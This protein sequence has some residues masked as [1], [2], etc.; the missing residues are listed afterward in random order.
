MTK[1]T[2]PKRIGLLGPFG[3]GNLGDAAIQHSMIQHIRKYFP[4]AQIYAF[5]MNPADTTAS[6]HIPAF[7]ITRL[8][9]KEFTKSDVLWKS[10]QLP[11]RVA[12]W[13]QYNPNPFIRRLEKVIVRVPAEMILA[14]RA[15]QNIKGL[16]MLIFSGGGQLDDLW[17][18]PWKHPYVLFKFSI[19]ARLQKIKVIFVSVGLESARTSLG[20]FFMKVALSQ[21]CYKS[22]RDKRSKEMVE[23]LKLDPHGDSFVY[24]D[25]A[26]SLEVMALP[27]TQVVN[28]SKPVVGFNPVPFYDPRFWPLKDKT[29]YQQYL[30]KMA[31]FV[32]WLIERQY[33]VKLIRSD[34][35][36]DQTAFSDILEV[37][38]RSGFRYTA[39]QIIEPQIQSLDDLLEQLSSSDIVVASRLHSVLL[40]QRVAKPVCAISYQSKIDRLMEDTGQADYC[41]PIDTFDVETLKQKF[42]TLE[43]NCETARKQILRRSKEYQAALDEQYDR[44]FK[45]IEA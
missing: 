20:R 1:S 27:T 25:L 16:D 9:E 19:L 24:P 40:A 34:I 17:G 23:Q 30:E 15:Y 45:L 41:L 38:K 26:H 28:P 31:S 37:L 8:P 32:Q 18:G 12:G 22:F 11:G 36:P 42:L 33:Q 7:P 5:S 21:A 44:I 3:F 43:A 4:D 2:S 39:E 10:K 13:F 29:V 6:H 14:F 35:Y